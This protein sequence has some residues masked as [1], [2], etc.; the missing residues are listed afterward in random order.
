M[1]KVNALHI[2]DGCPASDLARSLRAALPLLALMALF[3][4]AAACASP[5]QP[6]G[7]PTSAAQPT[8]T[9][10]PIPVTTLPE[11][12]LQ[13]SITPPVISVGD[14]FEVSTDSGGAGLAQY[15]LMIDGVTVCRVQHD[16]TLVTQTTASETQVVAWSAG[17][18]SAKWTVRAL[19]PGKYV[20]GIFVT[21]EAPLASGGPY[22]LT[23]GTQ[24]LRLTVES[25]VR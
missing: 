13:A 11:L 21:G 23:H 20:I 6:A 24:E 14:T 17:S 2:A 5:A 18:N 22:Y 25:V 16:G 3:T 4:L 9:T 8:P 10:E 15:T 7:S 19:T 1:L 12:T